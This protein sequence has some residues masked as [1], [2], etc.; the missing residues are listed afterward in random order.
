[1]IWSQIESLLLEN[2]NILDRTIYVICQNEVDMPQWRIEFHKRFPFPLVNVYF[3]TPNILLKKII[4]SYIK[5]SELEEQ[6]SLANLDDYLLK[7][8]IE[9][10]IEK[11]ISNKKNHTGFLEEII[12][13][14]T[15]LSWNY[16]NDIKKYIIQ[17]YKDY[18]EP[19]IK[20]TDAYLK[21]NNLESIGQWIHKKIKNNDLKLKE[22]THIL[23]MFPKISNKRLETIFNFIEVTLQ[24]TWTIIDHKY[25]NEK[26]KEKS[27]KNQRVNYF[28]YE[29]SPITNQNTIIANSNLQKKIYLKNTI[30]ELL[31]TNFL[32]TDI[33]ILYFNEHDLKDI[34]QISK[35]IGIEFNIAKINQEINQTITLFI[36]ILLNDNYIEI[37]K[38]F[39]LL[40]NPYINLNFILNNTEKSEKVLSVFLLYKTF[41]KYFPIKE[42]EL[43]KI[44]ELLLHKIKEIKDEDDKFYLSYL[45]KLIICL[46]DIKTKILTL[47]DT[48]SISEFNLYI[49]NIFFS[50]SDLIIA[51]ELAIIAN[52]FNQFYALTKYENLFENRNEYFL[53]IKNELLKKAPKKLEEAS[54][55][56]SLHIEEHSHS[57]GGII[58]RHISNGL[59]AF[60][61]YLIVY[62]IDHTYPYEQKH[63]FFLED[64]LPQKYN[65]YENYENQKNTIENLSSFIQ[66]KIIYILH[67]NYNDNYDRLFNIKKDDRLISSD[68]EPKISYIKKDFYE[69]NKQYESYFNEIEQSKIILKNRFFYNQSLS[70]ENLKY[71]GD[72]YSKDAP[73][74]KKT[75]SASS[76]KLFFECPQKYWFTYIL[77]LKEKN[78]FIDIGNIN[79]LHE[80]NLF[81]SI[82]A[83]FITELI[84]EYPNNT[85]N[86]I[87]NQKYFFIS[88]LRK[89]LKNI[90]DEGVLEYKKLNLYAGIFFEKEKARVYNIFSRFFVY[91]FYTWI[92]TQNEKNNFTNLIP[93]LIEHSFKN[94]KLQ[95]F[96]FEGKIDRVDYNEETKT[97][98]IFDYKKNK[99]SIKH[100]LEIQDIQA[101]VYT[102]AIADYCNTKY[103]TL[104]FKPERIEFYYLY[105][106][107]LSNNEKIIS[108]NFEDII[109]ENFISE[110]MKEHFKIIQNML[111][112]SFALATPYKE[113]NL[114]YADDSQACKLCTYKQICDKEPYQTTK[115][116]ASLDNNA[117]IFYK[118]IH[119]KI[120]SK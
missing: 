98:L 80:G 108:A 83:K 103:Y 54:S 57:A 33:C 4:R 35:E 16:D 81:H 107:D 63:N 99:N 119:K 113:N 79:H 74:L 88:D 28:F 49:K 110:E 104:N 1:M 9:K 105:Y 78:D 14:Y 112:R 72:L 30:Q 84:N 13:L 48:K 10:S 42:I 19:I 115:S 68:L 92:E 27:K 61:K 52:I 50:N 101:Y 31:N 56:Y 21:K 32:L 51:P 24:P 89:K 67:K 3:T 2:K 39:F 34:K 5:H 46:L 118:K 70:K 11:N 20:D 7:R 60:Y 65:I 86:N 93:W 97:I 87:K 59:G 82:A 36:D 69:N 22:N 15:T 96:I 26:I 6:E 53:Y 71:L 45:S 120:H 43:I 44:N 116:K 38:I 102:K 25:N 114:W 40:K 17:E 95:E 76:F 62:G 106:Q 47:D 111:H 8:I 109:S 73:I 100:N 91:F 66:N 58:T 77:N 55:F 29:S 18:I 85:Y 12:L 117:K 64:S 37:E 41:R 94:I 90:F 23:W 75:F